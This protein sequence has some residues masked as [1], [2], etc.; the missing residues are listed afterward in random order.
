[1]VTGR[2]AGKTAKA[3]IHEPEDLPAKSVSYIHGTWMKAAKFYL[4]W[5]KRAITML[6]CMVMALFF[7]TSEVKDMLHTPAGDRWRKGLR[8][9]DGSLS[10]RIRDPEVEKRFWRERIARGP[11]PLDSYAKKVFH[12]LVQLTAGCDIQS[13]LE[14]G[15]GWGN[16]SFPLSRRFAKLSC[17]DVSPDNLSYLSERV[18]AEGRC[19]FTVCS[20][21]EDAQVEPHDMVFAYNCFYRLKEPELFLQKV[22]D[23]A[24]KLC[25]IGM[26]RPP[27]LPWLKDMEKAGLPIHYTRQGCDEL[28]EILDEIGIEAQLVNIPNERIYRFASEEA[29]LARA[30]QFLMEPCAD[31]ALLPLLLPHHEKQEDGS[32]ICRYRFHSQLLVWKPKH[33]PNPAL[34]RVG[35]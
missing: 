21:W 5:Q 35:K 7:Y 4:Y 34:C 22:N 19:I 2:K 9:P 6:F 31:T 20:A 18:A 29:L 12:A 13:V 17:V 16:Y 27:E 1:M 8:R 14:I 25:I 32:L 3:M 30:R 24:E 23:S 26:N 33:E 10:E 11:I 28:L 15:P